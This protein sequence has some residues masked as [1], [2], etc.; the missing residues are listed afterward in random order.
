MYKVSHLFLYKWDEYVLFMNV[1]PIILYWSFQLTLPYMT[2]F[3]MWAKVGLGSRRRWQLQNL[4]LRWWIEYNCFKHQNKYSR[5]QF[6][7]SSILQQTS[8]SLMV[9]RYHQCWLQRLGFATFWFTIWFVNDVWFLC[10]TTHTTIILSQCQMSMC[11]PCQFQLI[12]EL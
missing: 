4:C 6:W 11:R 12:L 9:K 8:N 5:C 2:P 1:K 10:F 3:W 7:E